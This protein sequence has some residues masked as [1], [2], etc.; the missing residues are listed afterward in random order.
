MGGVLAARASGKESQDELLFIHE[1]E[2]INSS[3]S[4]NLTIEVSGAVSRPG[5]YEISRGSRIEDALSAAGGFSDQA[6][7]R[8]VDRNLN[9]AA[10]VVDGQKI[11]I[12]SIQEYEEA[13]QSG[14][15][16]GDSSLITTNPG[17]DT[18]SI[19]L[20]TASAGELESLWGIGPVTA[21]N[22]I[23]QRPYSS[24]QELLDKK[25]LR[26]DIFERNKDKLSI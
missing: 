10:L 2:T 15:V 3:I 14:S 20:N 8:W 23:E 26:K 16:L 12:P 24:V 13:L 5:V 17:A 4:E 21:Q 7:G 6:D 11:Y 22:I 25:I 18:A 1:G 19:N 9:R